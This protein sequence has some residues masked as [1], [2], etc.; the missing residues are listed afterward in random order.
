MPFSVR[1]K[2]DAKTQ[3]CI[4]ETPDVGTRKC[5]LGSERILE[6]QA[7]VQRPRNCLASPV[8]VGA[9]SDRSSE[10]EEAGL[11]GLAGL[12]KRPG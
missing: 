11:A 2:H 3:S 12:T 10:T 4:T 7:K 8:E 5:Q 9:R 6:A 1:C